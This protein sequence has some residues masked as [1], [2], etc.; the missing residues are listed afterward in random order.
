[1]RNSTSQIQKK[2]IFVIALALASIVAKAQ[3]QNDDVNY[4][5]IALAETEEDNTVELA[6]TAVNISSTAASEKIMEL[7]NSYIMDSNKKPTPAKEITNS[8]ETAYDRS[9]AIQ[10]MVDADFLMILKRAIEET[11]RAKIENTCLRLSQK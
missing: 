5:A 10:E 11:K 4:T 7:T 1:M 6:T 3:S 9:S 2:I 8:S